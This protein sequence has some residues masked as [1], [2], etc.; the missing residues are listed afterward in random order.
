[1]E[2]LK[3]NEKIKK[4]VYNFNRSVIDEESFKIWLGQPYRLIYIIRKFGFTLQELEETTKIIVS[5]LKNDPFK[6]DSMEMTDCH[7]FYALALK[8]LYSNCR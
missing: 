2:I 6:L 3:Y 5:Y 1:M 4:I 8:F 7:Y